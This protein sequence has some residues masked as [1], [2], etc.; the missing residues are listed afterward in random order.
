MFFRSDG[1]VFERCDDSDGTI[2]DVFRLDACDLFVEYASHCESRTAMSDIVLDL[3]AHDSYGVRSALVERASEFFPPE[4]LRLLAERLWDLHLEHKADEYQARHFLMGVELLAQ[5]LRDPALFEKARLAMWPAISAAACVDI[6]CVYLDAGD[7]ETALLWLERIDQAERFK[8]EERDDLLFLAYQQSGDVNKARE[9]AW[10]I[11]RRQRN[12]RTLEQLFSVLEADKRGAVVD[13]QTAEIL[14]SPKFSFT[15]ARFLIDM[16]R[17][18]Q[19]EAYL[20][21]NAG[22]LN[23]DYYSSL[24]PLAESMEQCQHWL[25]VVLIYRACLDSILAR[26]RSKY[27]HHGVR[28]LKKLDSLA[29]KIDDWRGILP[30]EQYKR[31]LRQH[32]ARKRAFW[33]KYE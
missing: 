19:A 27:Y 16:G 10:R 7:A 15:D 8:E 20:L 31:A 21:R 2:G 11:F 17:I 33:S 1:A 23:G 3:Y 6:G 32:H 5:Q 4:F 24:L 13:E 18:E 30:H 29:P 25:P 26:A 22:Q 9:T 14:A 12:H 28:Y